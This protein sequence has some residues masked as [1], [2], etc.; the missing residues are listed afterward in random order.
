MA[1]GEGFLGGGVADRALLRLD[2][3]LGGR[4]LRTVFLL[5]D[6][7]SD[8]LGALFGVLWAGDG[9]LPL[10]PDCAFGCGWK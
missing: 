2:E 4:P 7:D 3:T 8:E 6:G 1:F 10:G 9:W 5:E